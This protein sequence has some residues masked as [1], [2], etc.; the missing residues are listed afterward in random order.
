APADPS[1]PEP[2]TLTADENGAFA[3]ELSLRAGTWD[4]TIAVEG[5]EPVVRR[6]RVEP[7]DGIRATLRVVDADSYLEV[8]EDG[9]PLADVSGGIAS[10]GDSFTLEADDE[11][12]I[13][14]GNAGAVRLVVNGIGLGA[15]GEDG[16]VVEWRIR[17]GQ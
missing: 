8:D 14:A 10:D 9:T 3:G 16:A 6:V 5:S 11:L 4:I 13:R 17:P 12:R 2:A 1:A 15:M 7:T